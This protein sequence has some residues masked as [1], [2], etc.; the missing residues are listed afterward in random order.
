MNRY[1]TLVRKQQ[2]KGKGVKTA[3]FGN[4]SSTIIPIL[5]VPSG[6]SPASTPAQRNH[7]KPP[8]PWASQSL[9]MIL[10]SPLPLS[11]PK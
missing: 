10:S 11:F 6:Q 5:T 8:P 2:E 9:H 1:F 3:K 7:H 4:I